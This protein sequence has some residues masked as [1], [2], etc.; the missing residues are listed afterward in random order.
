MGE[1]IFQ[2]ILDHPEG[3]W[4][5]RLDLDK[6]MDAVRTP[7]GRV[8]LFIP[9]LA[10]WVQEITPE[11]EEI[12]LES[13]KR[14]PLVLMA[15]HHMDTN[16]N[17]LMRDPAWNEGRRACVLSIHPRDAGRLV[18]A[19]A[20]RVRVVTE[21]GEV[22]IEARLTAATQPGFVVIPHG[23]GLEYAGAVH[24]ANVNRLTSATH[25]DRLAGTPI[26]RFV[27]CRVEKA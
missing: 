10:G 1:E 21:A 18:V 5:G 23:F 24:G 2:A 3:L 26:H 19:D 16:A 11:L 13:D 25:R 9:E 20:E 14:F 12:A 6:G 15:G 27:P 4:I 8:N 17:T 22:E 7:D